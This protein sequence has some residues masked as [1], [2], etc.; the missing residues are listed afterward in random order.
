MTVITIPGIYS[1]ITPNY[2]TEKITLSKPGDIITP[3]DSSLPPYRAMDVDGF[4]SICGDSA[5]EDQLLALAQAKQINILFHYGLST[6]L[7]SASGRTAMAAYALKASALGITVGAIRG[8]STTMIGSAKSSTKS[9][10]NSRTNAAERFKIYN[11]E[12]EFWNYLNDVGN[13]ELPDSIGNVIFRHWNT[14]LEDIR[15][16]A[17]EDGIQN[18]VYISSHAEDGIE[19]TPEINIC[20]EIIN[21]VDRVQVAHYIT[22]EEFSTTDRGWNFIDQ[23]IEVLA[24]AAQSLSKVI[25]VV[26]LFANTDEFMKDTFSAMTP[27][28]IF[29]IFMAYYNTVD[30]DGKEYINII[31]F[32]I[33]KY[34]EF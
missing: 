25:D 18:E 26:I 33:Y 27:V 3:P 14:Y 6:L 20:V 29:R 28:E 7:A 9:Y 32:D 8:S 1:A 2:F 34:S 24:L 11:L 15:T 17:Q 19:N 5:K 16:S 10:N 31:G 23:Q 13:I 21:N 4:N 22:D 12:N 30:F